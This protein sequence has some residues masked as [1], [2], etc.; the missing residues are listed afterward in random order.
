MRKGTR[1]IFGSVA[2]AFVIA[3]SAGQAQ[4]ADYW[5]CV[6]FARMISG[7]QIFGDAWTWWKQ[8]AGKYA[9]GFAPKAGAVLVFKPNGVMDKGH[10]AVVSQVLTDRVIQVTQ[11]NWSI[12]DGRRGQVERDV[13]VVDVSPAGDWSQVKVWYDPVRDLGKTVYP[14]Y[15]FIYQTT[16][17]AAANA[18][19]TAVRTVA[20]TAVNQLTAA[21]PAS[22]ANPA[23]ALAQAAG[24]TDQISAL[25]QAATGS[26]NH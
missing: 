7:I 15:G 22:N 12:I 18:A 23:H 3:A 26:D 21:V 11:A 20:Q 13:T 8:A 16:Q 25:I 19:E 9:Q 10:V 5:Q 24:S 17:S 14:T 1:A 6:P 2:A 4:A